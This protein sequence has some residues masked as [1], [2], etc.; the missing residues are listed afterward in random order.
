MAE[1]EQVTFFIMMTLRA[2]IAQ[3]DMIQIGIDQL[4]HVKYDNQGTHSHPVI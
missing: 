3:T 1:S 2:D 4:C